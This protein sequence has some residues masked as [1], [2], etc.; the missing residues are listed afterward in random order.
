MHENST[1][2]ESAATHDPFFVRWANNR[3]VFNIA[4]FVITLAA[5]VTRFL[6]AENKPFHHDE[7][8]HAYYSNRVANGNPHVYDGMLHGPFLYYFV[9]SFMFLLGKLGLM[10]G[11]GRD[12]IAH[13]PASLFGVLVVLSPLFVR[14]FI[15]NLAT[16]VLM[17][18]LLVSPVTMYFG[19]FLREDVF[20]SIWVLGT[21]MALF[22]YALTQKAWALYTAVA[23]LALHFTNKENSYLHTFVWGLGLFLVV[24]LSKKF[25]WPED[26]TSARD[27]K[28]ILTVNSL[29]LFIAIFVLFYSAFFTYPKGE[30]WK[31]VIDGLYAK[32]LVYWWEQD[33][34]RRID[35]PFDYHLPILATYEFMLVPFVVLAW[36]R[37][38]SLS[39]SLLQKGK[40]FFL[41]NHTAAATVTLLVLALVTSFAP[42][43]ALVPDGCSIT[44][45]CLE[46]LS[47]ALS[48]TVTP[49][50]KALHI[51]HSRHFLQIVLYLY[52]GATA[53]FFAL[54]A[55]HR[56]DAFLW[57]WLTASLGIYSY[58][59]EKVPWLTVYIVLPMVLVAGLELAR[60]FGRREL[61]FVPDS[62][63]F[64][65]AS[66]SLS[67]KFFIAACV[68]LVLSFPITV[69]KAFRVSFVRPANPQERLVFT[70]T[71]P[72][73]KF[74][75][76]RWRAAKSEKPDAALKVTV[77]GEATWPFAWYVEEFPGFDFSKPTAE[78]ADKFDA[79]ILDMSE[80]ENAKRN[81]RNFRFFSLP[82]RAWWIPSPNPTLAGALR[83]FFT[84]QSYVRPGTEDS[85]TP[86][87]G[88]GNTSVLYLEKV[89]NGSI[90][91][92]LALPEGLTLLHNPI[93]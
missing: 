30:W 13:V 72:E 69:H 43:L 20:T 82:L 8:L 62:H 83:Y 10:Q 46:S 5:I 27:D 33:Q 73:A 16:L 35:G 50:A 92:G 55:R 32:S 47:P 9:G 52:G 78:H 19:R 41:A 29:S 36:Y 26:K 14:R 87:T 48:K 60:L 70:Q 49:F 31:G 42:R 80:L 38:A 91:E 2:Q 12:I 37:T 90:F 68:W 7:S 28:L 76:D 84:G 25:F 89:S 56:V 22:R 4:L 45:F 85:P 64:D 39:R 1:L 79:M 51:A 44:E 57:F 66:Q 61:T 58:V 63:D 59:G 54:H 24:Q 81:Y 6:D 88:L 77:A 21:L 71:T 34:K 75:R 93:P 86:D 53:F 18:L 67:K 3:R 15:G 17:L 23:L 65:E 11:A 74:V 40:Q